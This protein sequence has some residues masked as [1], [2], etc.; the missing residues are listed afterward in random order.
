MSRKKKPNYM[1]QLD[2][3]EAEQRSQTIKDARDLLPKLAEMSIASAEAEYDGYGDQGQIESI[4]FLDKKNKK[5]VAAK[6]LESEFE[7][8]ACDFLEAQRAG[9]EINEGAY[10]KVVLDVRRKTFMIQHNERFEDSEYS[11]HEERL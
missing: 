4:S 9:W 2:K 5:V 7:R 3:K 10:G 6:D 8:I 11:E 1:I